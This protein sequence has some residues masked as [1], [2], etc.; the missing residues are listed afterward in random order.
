MRPLAQ[1]AAGMHCMQDRASIAPLAVSPAQ[2][3]RLAGIGRT[4]LYEAIR[5]GELP[6]LKLGA[7]RLIRI[8]DLEAW[9]DR[10]ADRRAD[11]G[12]GNND[13]GCR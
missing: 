12:D 5:S 11:E 1:L 13:S 9:L 7:R 2:A 10:H 4:R 3:A 6:S 8:V